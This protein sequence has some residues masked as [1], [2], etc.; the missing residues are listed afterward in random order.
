MNESNEAS[1]P[2]PQN[3]SVSGSSNCSPCPGC[4]LVAELEWSNAADIGKLYCS[5]RCAI[6]CYWTTDIHKS[7]AMIN[8][9]IK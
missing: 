4:G 1:N 3:D 9:A 6:R 5:R 2:E 7:L 8:E